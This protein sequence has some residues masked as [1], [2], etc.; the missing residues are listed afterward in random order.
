MKAQVAKKR[1]RVMGMILLL[2]GVGC[3]IFAIYVFGM[4]M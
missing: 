2:V 4:E 3:I 1:R